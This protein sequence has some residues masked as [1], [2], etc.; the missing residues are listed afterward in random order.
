[1]HPRVLKELDDVVAQPL[2]QSEKLCQSGEV[3]GDW[4][5]GKMGTNPCLKRVERKALRI[6][7][8]SALSLVLGKT[9][10]KSS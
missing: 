5:K 9:W 7:N 1:M 8:L 2:S 4:K 3:L 6:T 10:S